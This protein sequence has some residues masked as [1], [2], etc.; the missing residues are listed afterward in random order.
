MV[1]ID[2]GIATESNLDLLKKRGYNY[3]CMSRTKLKE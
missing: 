3:L 1:V 2:A